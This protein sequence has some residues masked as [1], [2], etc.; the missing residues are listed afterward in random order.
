[1]ISAQDLVIGGIVTAWAEY[2]D[3]T[4]LEDTMW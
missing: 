4:N 1:M 2:L 3:Q